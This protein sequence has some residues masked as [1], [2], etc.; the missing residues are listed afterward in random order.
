ML[1]L[2]NIEKTMS[3]ILLIGISLALVFVII[4]EFSY[5]AKVGHESI[6]SLVSKPYPTSI[7]HL[8]HAHVVLT[9]MGLIELGLLTLI[10]TQVIRIVLLLCYYSR[11]RD[12]VF[13]IITLFILIVLCYSLF[14]Q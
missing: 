9:S 1:Q 11:A 14:S 3:V 12:Y 2:K 4:G 8:W 5:L 6:Y 10:G 13:A 7:K